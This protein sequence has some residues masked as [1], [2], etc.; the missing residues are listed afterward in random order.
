MTDKKKKPD[1]RNW[2]PKP[3]IARGLTLHTWDRGR[4]EYVKLPAASF[5]I[6]THVDEMAADMHRDA[7]HQRRAEIRRI[8]EDE[9][10]ETDDGE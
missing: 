10:W 1:L 9:G 2:L 7:L 5:P 6:P 4:D 3:V 8:L